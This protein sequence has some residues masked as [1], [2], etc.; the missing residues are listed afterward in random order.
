MAVDKKGRENETFTGIP[1]APGIAI[2]NAFVVNVEELPVGEEHISGHMVEEEIERFEE[3]L[4]EAD[5][6]LYQLHKKLR[7]DM[8]EEHA[9]ILD[10]HRLIVTD[11]E[12]QKNTIKLIRDDHLS[13]ASAFGKVI[14]RVLTSF[15][16]IEDQYLKERGEDIRDVRRRVVRIL[17]G[18]K[19]E[20]LTKLNRKAVVVA[21]NLNPSDTM[22]LK[23]KYVLAYV[24]DVG[25]STSH[26]A[27]IARS[28][29]IPSVVGLND[30]C[31]RVRPNDRII[32][33]GDTGRV[34]LNPSKETEKNYREARAKYE[35][36][37]RELLTFKDYPAVTLD[38]KTIELSGNIEAIDE[39]ED[40]LSHGGRGIGL[41]RTEYFFITSDT[42]PSEEQQYDYYR[43]VIERVAPDPV[44]IRTLDVG[45]DKIARWVPQ[46]EE[47]N[48]FM[49]WRGIR[50]TLS[51][52]DIFRTQ[53]RA[54]YRAAVHGKIRIMFP[55]I[56]VIEEVRNSLEI[57]EEVKEDLKNERYRID[58]DV[59]MGIMI[60]TPAAVAMADR[61]AKE[62]DFFSIGTND[63]TQYVL[64]VD[65]G[66]SKISYL[67]NALHPSI[68][69]MLRDTVE[70]A[71]RNGIWVGIC[72]EMPSDVFGT[73]LLI[74]LG[75]DE[76]SASSYIIPEIKSI[77]R[78]VTYDETKA[79]ANKAI[80]CSTAEEIRVMLTKF[81][82]E[83]RPELKEFIRK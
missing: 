3:A 29:G 13:A 68:I 79:L 34:V 47:N 37:E 73:L 78:S 8:G 48:P 83:K 59:E 52:R 26:A 62:V 15:D 61:M 4:Q 21:R 51:R 30:F 23:K 32:V 64:A 11:K 71:H 58:E 1:A 69:R 12:M 75:L 49:G 66:N 43:R 10:S 5:R 54:I 2:G 81:I 67:Y 45:G 56:S 35:E 77:I 6:E 46:N 39:V 42:L 44:I 27:I 16:E 82:D 57:C 19:V 55:M 14:E 70:A 18:Q 28:Q 17:L 65:R 60:E 25:G 74:G 7:D 24:T 72:G 53:L 40:L 33:D 76:F 20:R 36:M 50:F 41:F 38:G 80:N 63:L 9:R 31:L 22:G